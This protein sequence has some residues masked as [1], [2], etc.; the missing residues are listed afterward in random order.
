MIR[1]CKPILMIGLILPFSCTSDD[2]STEVVQTPTTPAVEAPH[3]RMIQIADKEQID[4]APSD[5]FDV[6]DAKIEG[7]SL[8]LV[9]EY[10]GGCETHEFEL[11]WDGLFLEEGPLSIKTILAHNAHND[12]CEAMI[13]KEIRFDLTLLKQSLR[14]SYP[15]EV[16]EVT[17]QISGT[18]LKPMFSIE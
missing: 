15:D 14:K 5:Q 13:Q 2:A 9:V 8:V 1:G 12:S 10:G 6:F 11:Y 4:S 18:K 3:V 17:I 7:N 16:S